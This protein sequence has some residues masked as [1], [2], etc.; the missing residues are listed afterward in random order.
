MHNIHQLLGGS[1]L[2]RALGLP[3]DNITR[4]LEDFHGQAF[5][6]HTFPGQEF[7]PDPVDL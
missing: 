4:E 1:Y 3:V 5:G 7:F 6:T 2:L